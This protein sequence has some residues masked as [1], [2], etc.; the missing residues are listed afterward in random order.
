MDLAGVWNRW[1]IWWLSA[2]AGALLGC[3]FRSMAAL[4]SRMFNTIFAMTVAFMV[5]VPFAMGY[6]SVHIYLASRPG[7]KTAAWKW[8]LLPLASV[9]LSMAVA[10]LVQWEGYICLMVASPILLFSAFVGGITGRVAWDRKK[11]R[12][13]GRTLLVTALPLIVLIVE[14]QLLAPWET[15]TVRTQIG[16][17]LR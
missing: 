13:P 8:L 3:M 15:R 1:K 5:V 7:Q 17:M 10:L 12:A 2:L 16:S 11:T 4:A 6:V 14:S 9:L